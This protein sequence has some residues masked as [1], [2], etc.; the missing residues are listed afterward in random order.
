MASRGNPAAFDAPLAFPS[1]ACLNRPKICPPDG[2]GAAWELQNR[3]RRIARICRLACPAGGSTKIWNCTGKG[4]H[5]AHGWHAHLG[6][7][8]NAAWGDQAPNC[9][10]KVGTTWYERASIR[11]IEAE[12]GPREPLSCESNE[13][14]SKVRES[15]RAIRAARPCYE[16]A[17][18]VCSAHH[19]CSRTTLE[20]GGETPVMMPLAAPGTRHMW[21]KTQI[22]AL[23]AR[24]RAKLRLVKLRASHARCPQ[25]TSYR[26]LGRSPQDADTRLDRSSVET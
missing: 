17:P 3:L 11:R 21:P 19:K 2:P 22:R 4:A 25:S 13:A 12:R 24:L 23:G 8:G 14:A 10:G 26:G 6:V 1:A 15:V 20:R 18:D 5:V 16:H 9:W 7:H